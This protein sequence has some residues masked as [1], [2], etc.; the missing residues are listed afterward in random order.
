METDYRSKLLLTQVKLYFSDAY[1][2]NTWSQQRIYELLAIICIEMTKM[3]K[4][5]N[6]LHCW[7]GGGEGRRGGGELWWL[8]PATFNNINSVISWRSVLLVEETRVPGENHHPVASDF[9][10]WQTLSDNELC[11]TRFELTLAVIGTN[12]IDR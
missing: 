11:C 4:Y 12:Y 8:M 10:H 3:Y 6:Y 7:F 1:V 2:M 9:C 5:S